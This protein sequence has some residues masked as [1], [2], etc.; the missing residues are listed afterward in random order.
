MNITIEIDC[1]PGGPRP[2]F[3]LE[4]VLEG[5]G[6][7]TVDKSSAFFGNW[8]FEIKDVKEEVWETAKPIIAERLKSL[9]NSGSIRY[10]S[11][12]AE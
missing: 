4:Q 7:P 9:H 8:T 11:W 3:Y 6:I 2:D 12:D 1:A 5:T 10:A